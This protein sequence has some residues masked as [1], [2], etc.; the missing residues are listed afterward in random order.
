M[1]AGKSHSPGQISRSSN[2][3]VL[4]NGPSVASPLAPGADLTGL[5]D[6]LPLTS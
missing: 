6:T 4:Q 5:P 1:V 2:S 3:F